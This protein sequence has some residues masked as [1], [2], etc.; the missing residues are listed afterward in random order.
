MTT[1]RYENTT[2]ERFQEFCQALFL[3][4]F[5][6]LQCFPIG[7]PDGGRDGVALMNQNI[8]ILQV[9][10]KRKDELA[11]DTAAWL[12]SS[13]EGEI[14]KVE[15]LKELGAE[16]YIIISNASASSHLHSGQRDRVTAWLN[17]NMP[18]PSTCYWRDDLDRRFERSDKLMWRYVELLDG[19]DAVRMLFES[20]IT[21][22]RARRAMAVR[23]FVS[24]QYEAD[25]QVKFK[26]VELKNDLFTLFVDVPITPQIRG[27]RD[28]KRQ[29]ALYWQLSSRIH[30]GDSNGPETEEVVFDSV[31]LRPQHALGAASILLDERMQA[32]FP[33]VLLEGAPG[34]GKSTLAQYI[35]QVHRVRFLNKQPELEALPL[36]HSASPL[37]IP[38]KVD[39]RDLATWLDR[40]DPFD[41]KHDG[42]PND[43]S[44]SLESFL[45]ALISN[46]SGG[47]RFESYDLLAS[48]SNAPILLFL[49]GL[50]EVAEIAKR[51]DLIDAVTSGL[52]RLDSHDLDVQVV[53]TSRPA[54]F[55]NS[56]GFTDDLFSYWLLRDLPLKL[57]MKYSEQWLVARELEPA[58][59]DDVR[60]ILGAKLELP[61]I[62]DL[63]RNPMQLAILLSLIHSIGFSLPDK[64]TAMYDAYMQKFLAREAEKSFAVREHRDLLVRLHRYLAWL[65]QSQAESGRTSGGITTKELRAE[66]TKYLTDSGHQLGILDD[67]FTGMV[68]R[69][70]VLVQRVEGSYEFDVQPIREYFAAKHLYETA[71]YSPTGNERSGTK[72]QRLAALVGNRYWTNVTRFY[73]GCYSSGELAD[74]LV[75]VEE[76]NEG[77]S[78]AGSLLH[79]RELGAMLLSDWVFTQNPNI[80]RRVVKAVFDPIG[81]RGAARGYDGRAFNGAPMTLPTV[82]ARQTLN[83][84]LLD[85][86][87]S[88]RASGSVADICRLMAS[89]VDPTLEAQ[90]LL[91]LE[92]SVGETKSRWLET[93]LRAGGFGEARKYD[94]LAIVRNEPEQ[95]Q[96][97]LIA[98]LRNR[99]EW[100][101][102]DLSLYAE[103]CNLLVAGELPRP[104]YG[105]GR[106]MDPLS[107]FASICTSWHYGALLRYESYPS[108]ARLHFSQGELSE[109]ASCD[110]RV[111]EVLSIFRETDRESARWHNSLEPWATIVDSF[112][113]AFGETWTG[114]C[115]ACVSVGVVN[116]SERGDIGGGLF[117]SGVNLARRARAV[118]SRR[119]KIEDWMLWLDATKDGSDEQSFWALMA[120]TWGGRL[121]PELCAQIRRVVDSLDT[122]RFVSMFG[123]VEALGNSS[124]KSG[125]VA[126]E[127]GIDE[128]GPRLYALLVTRYAM[129]PT[130]RSLDRLI[131]SDD[132]VL[133]ELGRACLIDQFA[134]N[135]AFLK[136]RHWR[137]HLETIRKSYCSDGIP[138]LGKWFH[139]VEGTTMAPQAA[140]AIFDCPWE[141]PY[142][143]VANAAQS[144]Q[145][146]A[147]TETVGEVAKREK[148]SF[149]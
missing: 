67:L 92:R 34:Q 119:W 143:L 146:S 132:G 96:A 36:A 81:I 94:C 118:R 75:H 95:M 135:G 59:A 14:G 32:E 113:K 62:R 42:V 44:A 97:R 108:R 91:R 30:D 140:S 137:K 7:Q 142:A 89:N 35:C 122:G 39:L 88:V 106:G 20:S 27:K 5:P 23:S 58:D 55:A 29:D 134:K 66:L 68:E 40:Q 114:Y 10:F 48:L 52:R 112:R 84:L 69:V 80:E 78:A 54:A 145:S 147:P 22:D 131:Q 144:R 77:G 127:L 63:S 2:P 90:F 98:I 13:L 28:D 33:K 8:A 87:E 85:Q 11:E 110:P 12:I 74:L 124:F 79:V 107:L 133:S 130:S 100:L 50:D 136:G 16:Q 86:L 128:L 117:D 123:V 70:F 103:A 24:S 72:P 109:T 105:T 45:S 111:D 126:A 53:A 18:L 31:R 46:Y 19:A 26:Q 49:D 41:P 121:T 43:W 104:S 101:T 73:A 141:F 47:I 15:R 93:G 6:G 60:A 21:E 76:L 65:L 9:K 125:S 99:P 138:N 56:P 83:S 64:R 37:R 51:R 61:H 115:I 82:T 129:D 25:S 102:S 139:K 149:E 4:D 17:A 57:V 1:F 38:I 71:P 148:W 120:V 3:P 116:R